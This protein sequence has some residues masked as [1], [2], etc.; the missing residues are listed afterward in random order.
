ME[1]NPDGNFG[2]FTYPSEDNADECY[3][4]VSID[5][6][7][8]VSETTDN[9]AAAL[10]FLEYATRSEV[11]SEWC[12]TASQLSALTGVECDTLPQAAQDIANEIAKSMNKKLVVKDI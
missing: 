3:V 1:Y 10:A 7:W 8:M 6:S 11:N 9:E 2:G 4:P 5:D 12:G